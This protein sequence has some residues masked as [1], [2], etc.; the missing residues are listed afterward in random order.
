M[1]KETIEEKQ[2]KFIQSIDIIY[3]KAIDWVTWRGEPPA[4]VIWKKY[5]KK[6]DNDKY[7]A[8]KWLIKWQYYKTFS[9][10]FAAWIWGLAMLPFTLPA[11]LTSSLF[12]ELRMIWAIAY[13]WW[14]DLSSKKA[15]TL[16][17]MCLLWWNVKKVLQNA[18]IKIWEK[19][20]KGILTKIPEQMFIE[21]NKKI[22]ISLFS[23]LSWRWII[24]VSKAVPI[25]W[26]FIWWWIN[27]YYT[28]G[29]WEKALELFIVDSM[30]KE[31]K[32]K[33]SIN[34]NKETMLQKLNKIKNNS[35][36]F[37]KNSNFKENLKSIK[38]GFKKSGK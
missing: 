26:W 12:I 14:Y 35:K 15:K 25:M 21:I 38:E 32:E 13:I 29:I 33:Y 20:I 18:W 36:E 9:T 31:E 6:Y 27:M 30:T 16:I 19:T 2:N 1:Q 8:T 28:K 34:E 22:W 7:L 17:L 11:D 4:Q 24:S 5:L 3:N 37:V 23:K 10:W